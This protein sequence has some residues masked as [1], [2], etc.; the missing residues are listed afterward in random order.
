MTR[1]RPPLT[2]A[3]LA[4]L[5]MVLGACSDSAESPRSDT[6]EAE[7]ATD[8]IRI[9]VLKVQPHRVVVYDELPGRVSARRTAEIRPQV[10]GIVRSVIFTEGAEV[11]ADQP[12]FQIDPAPFAA[13]VEA[14]S[15]VLARAEADLVNATVKHERVQAL[16][17]AQA[18]SAAALGDAKAALAQ[19]RASV[20]EA[21]ANLSRRELELAHATIRSP[22]AGRIGQALTSEGGLASVGAATALAVVQQIDS[23]YLDVRQSSIRRE[24]VEER[25][26]GSRNEDTGALPV[27]I[28]TI[29]GKR[30]EFPGKILFS[31]STVDPGTG[32]IA[33]RVEVPNPHRQ[34]LPGMYLHARVA[35]AIYPDALTVPQ[36]AVRRDPSGRA[37]LAVIGDD[38]SA[39]TRDVELGPLVERQ[40]VV[41]SGLRPGET[42]VVE[43][44]DRTGAGQKLELVPYQLSSPKT[45]I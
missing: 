10:N 42:V 28:L 8:P 24:Q 45:Q 17:A 31:E 27:Q 12:L 20:A 26:D 25:L 33:M 41:L 37:Q 39:R 16:M 15:A 4:A 34:L 23:V 44:Q 38:N 13:D 1:L 19:A 40:Y 29:T 35:S 14:A 3:L 7:A 5:A 36:Q 43:G 22:I 18:T 2:F 21:G 6:A 9:S 32:S 11:L 30:Y